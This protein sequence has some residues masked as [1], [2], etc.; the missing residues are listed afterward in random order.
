MEYVSRALPT[1]NQC[2]KQTNIKWIKLVSLLW[3]DVKY[4]EVSVHN[5]KSSDTIAKW[6]SAFSN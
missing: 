5:T 3:S 2:D 6:V 1:V 4:I